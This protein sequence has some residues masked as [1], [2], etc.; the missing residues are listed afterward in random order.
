MKLRASIWV[1]VIVVCLGL[2]LWQG[3]NL[4]IIWREYSSLNRHIKYEDHSMKI[5]GPFIPPKVAKEDPEATAVAEVCLGRFH[6]EMDERIE[7]VAEKLIE[8]PDNKFLLF[9]LVRYLC[10]DGRAVDPQVTLTFVERLIALEPDNANYHYI[11]CYFLLADRHG[12]DID[13][14]LEK[15]EYANKCPRYDLPYSDY[16]QRAINIANKAK[17]SRFLL[18]E[19]QRYE[20]ENP[21]AFDIWEQLIGQASAAFTDGD[22]AKG[23]RI[24]DA[25]AEMQKRQ[26][27]DGEPRAISLKNLMFFSG[28]CI[29]GHWQHPLGLE[30]QRVNLAKEQARNNRLQ[31][32]ALMASRKKP[33]EKNKNTNEKK[34]EKQT[35]SLAAYPAVHVGEMFVAFLWVYVILLFASA[36]R[37]FGE[38]N[39]L[40]FLDI[41]LFIIGCVCYF[42]IV[43]GF[44]LVSLLESFCYFSYID[45]LRPIPGLEYIERMPM[46]VVLF[47]AGPIVAALALWGLGFLKPKRGAFW[48][49][50]YVRVPVSLVM[51]A[52]AAFIALCTEDFVSVALWEGCVVVGVLAG[53]LAWVIITVAWWLFRCRIVRLFLVATFLGSITVLASGY[54]YVHYLPMIVFILASATIAVVKTNEGSAFKTVLRLFS[55]K[56]DV[57]A[58]R[59]KCL[60]LIA[61]FIVV[62]W[63]LFIALMPLLAKSINL[64][65]GEFKTVDRRAILP[66]ANEAYQE[67]TSV[68]EAEGLSKMDIHRLLGLVMPED[69][70]TLLQKLKNKEFADYYLERLSSWPGKGADEEEMARLKKVRLND[71]DLVLAMN[72]CGRD[73]AGIVTGFLDEPDSER[74]LVVRA[75]LG[76]STAKEKL[77]ELLQT[78]MQSELDKKE[79]EQA[80][81]PRT[82]L[83][84][85][86][87]AAEII[88]ALACVSEPNE[89]TGR[90]LDYIQNREVSDLFEDHEFFEG[91]TLL[92]TTQAR[93]V[94]KSYLDK[95][96]SWQPRVE[97]MPYGLFRDS[98][99]R[100]L[101]PLR[102][103]VGLYGDKQIAEEFFQIMLSAANEDGDFES[104]DIS[105]YFEDQTAELLKKGL[106]CSNVDMRAWCIWQLRKIG[107]KFSKPELKE[108]LKDASWKVRTNV[109]LAGGKEAGTLAKNDNNTLV[110]LVA[111]F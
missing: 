59:N 14:A 104:F 54:R 77:E 31:L 8:Y 100:V 49:L 101:Y 18:T 65:F 96:R 7:A 10:E 90:F 50:W 15:L 26:L 87:R 33:A 106:T 19:L 95:A 111:G 47:L 70:P 67:V 88:G 17:L 84:I 94:I 99:D 22:T 109:V 55:R 11:K 68:F 42:C 48:R 89:A 97:Q 25:L 80:K 27:R 12:N 34:E 39:K 45:A 91:L 36:A 21:V 35:A 73:V 38:R 105:P 58:I 43:K 20:G 60:R 63:G 86:A 75:R 9:E 74:A 6:R 53:V 103:F 4:G 23:M 62:Y 16:R 46:L 98:P 56:P 64:E 37:G 76:D 107:Y 44:F 57:A 40:G 1:V 28:P 108:L 61:P 24:T 110:R 93:R 5:R 32:C 79:D 78:K 3:E 82:Y 51:G 29:F 81:H 92:S 85:P 71:G 83:D 13:A 41:L 66:D 69:L 72:G 2:G 30:L 102:K 52:I